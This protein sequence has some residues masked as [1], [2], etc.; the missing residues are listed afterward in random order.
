MRGWLFPLLVAPLL[1]FP[2]GLAAQAEPE[3]QLVLPSGI[4][5]RAGLGQYS[6]RDEYFSAEKY[7]GTLPYFS[8]TWARFHEGGG[9]RI[10]VAHRNSSE[11]SNH[12]LSAGVT[13]FSLNLDFLYRIAR[14]PV[15]SREALLFLGPSTG[16]FMHFSELHIAYSELEIPYSF[17]MIL[18]LGINSTVAVPVTD[19]LQLAGSLRVSLFSLGLRMIDIDEDVDEESPVRFLTL[20]SGSNGYFHLGFGYALTDRLSLNIGYQL[21]VLRIRRWDPLLSASD[22][23]LVGFTVGF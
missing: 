10:G 8:A 19:R 9:Y 23:L 17:A 15:F 22:N 7:S 18:P 3:T 1:F 21:Q 12:N 2:R 6:V 13:S 20:P 11:I 5:I 16:F 4:S 14:F